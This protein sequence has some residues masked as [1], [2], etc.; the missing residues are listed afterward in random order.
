MGTKLGAHTHGIR[1]AALPPDAMRVCWGTCD[2]RPGLAAAMQ[3]PSTHIPKSG[4]S[5]SDYIRASLTLQCAQKAR[6]IYFI[7]G[8]S[9]ELETQMTG[10]KA[11]DS[12]KMAEE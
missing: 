11:H 2:G 10:V 6:R 12:D 9:Q 8:R 4:S 1:S 3:L 7:N 5:D